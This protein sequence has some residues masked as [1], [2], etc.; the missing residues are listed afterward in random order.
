MPPESRRVGLGVWVSLVPT[1]LGILIRKLRTSVLKDGS[2]HSPSPNPKSRARGSPHKSSPP[3]KRMGPSKSGSCVLKAKESSPFARKVFQPLKTR[4]RW[5]LSPTHSTSLPAGTRP[6]H[7]PTCRAFLLPASKPAPAP[8][9]SSQS[10]EMLSVPRVEPAAENPNAVRLNSGEIDTRIDSHS[11]TES[12]K[13][14]NQT[15]GKGK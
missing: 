7:K 13:K 9:F 2:V 1:P 8:A 12:Q 15:K 6:P 4:V 5:G 10:A 3:T 11:R 14:K